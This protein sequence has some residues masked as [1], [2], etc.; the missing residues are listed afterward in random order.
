[1]TTR[2]PL[3]AWWYF[4]GLVCLSLLQVILLRFVKGVPVAGLAATGW[5]L[6]AAGLSCFATLVI[7][8]LIVGLTVLVRRGRGRF[9][10]RTML[11]AMALSIAETV[12]MLIQA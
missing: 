12:L 5:T 7:A 10:A 1:M 3:S 4:G 11:S 9:G 2:R 8:A 6:F